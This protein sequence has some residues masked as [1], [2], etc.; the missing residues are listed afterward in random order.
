MKY[1]L[2]SH[3]EVYDSEEI[4]KSAKITRG[5]CITNDKQLS[6][7]VNDH[8][9]G[10]VKELK[11]VS[12]EELVEKGAYSKAVILHRELN[13]CKLVESHEYVQSLRKKD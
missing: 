12:V 2:G 7:F 8:C 3:D 9:K 1:F 11:E 5:I 4:I 10:I 13:K 6:R